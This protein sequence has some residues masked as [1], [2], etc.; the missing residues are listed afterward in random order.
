MTAPV[1]GAPF[2]PMPPDGAGAPRSP[3]LGN[4]SIGSGVAPAPNGS[5]GLSLAPAPPV[6]ADRS[7]ETPAG[8]PGPALSRP[9]WATSDRPAWPLQAAPAFDVSIPPPLAPGRPL[10]PPDGEPRPGLS[11]P[12]RPI[13]GGLTGNGGSPA[14]LRQPDTNGVRHH[15][16]APHPGDPP[17]AWRPLPEPA[18]ASPQRLAPHRTVGRLAALGPDPESETAGR[19]AP[20]PPRT[21]QD[22]ATERVRG[23]MKVKPAK[24]GVRQAVRSL[25]FGVIKPG[26]G[27][28][29]RRERE[30][31][32]TATTPIATCRRVAIVSR[33][34]GIGKTTTTL[35]LGHTF[36]L[37]R[38][39]R[40]VALDAN[41]D[42][43]SLAYRV[44]RETEATV[45]Q[46]LRA[47]ERLRRYSDMRSFT[48]QA[49]TRLEVLA[50]DDDPTISVALG[51]PEYRQVLHVLEHHYNLI[52]MDTGTG[53][54][55]S[56]TQGILRMADQ[57]VV[58]AAPGIDASR[59]SSLTLDWLDEHGYHDLVSDAVVVINQ[60]RGNG[61][62][63]MKQ[64]V[65]HFA[66]RCRA[67]V[68][69][70]WD[71]HLAEGLEVDVDELR[72]QTRTAYL[73]AVAAVARSFSL[74]SRHR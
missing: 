69:V 18:L 60:V 74:P 42:A 32:V 67:V 54:L 5:P 11:A 62:R 68:K 64:V 24:R 44:H 51:E 25:S 17:A 46:L 9:A 70:P 71:A 3:L 49:S 19:P 16:G 52:L 45:T 73:N 39:D 26:P 65:D 56:A 33:K 15:G 50:S 7:P 35:M 12:P 2:H 57:I 48:N 8:A 27:R 22:F 1:G 29:E 38:G 4:G 37:C 20:T 72:P 58:C 61:G 6:T 47:S 34:G 10:P 31:A 63:E 55:D 41:P 40:V 43:G 13:P 21:A 36:A 14:G 28:S 66:K 59:A 53:I 23:P 30:L